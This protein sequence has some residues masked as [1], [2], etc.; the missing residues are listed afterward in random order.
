MMLAQIIASVAEVIE[1]VS[2][3]PEVDSIAEKAVAKIIAELGPEAQP[4][5]P[6]SDSKAFKKTRAYQQIHQQY[7]RLDIPK[8]SITDF[9][10]LATKVLK[11]IP[12]IDA[13]NEIG[14]QQ[15]I[16]Y[17]SL[18]KYWDQCGEKILSTIAQMAKK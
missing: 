4:S 13:Q 8:L 18:S 2:K 14:I 16:L 3:H 1:I 9:R 17:S 6:E 15:G 10:A 5:Q 11:G 7:K 12:G